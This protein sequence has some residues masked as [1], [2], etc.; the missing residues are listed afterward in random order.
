M[1]S[2]IKEEEAVP[3]L[4]PEALEELRAEVA[5]Q[6]DKVKQLKEV[7]TGSTPFHNFL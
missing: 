2:K 1:L 5:G 6:A 4:S 7:R 3:K